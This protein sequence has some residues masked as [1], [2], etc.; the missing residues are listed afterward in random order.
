MIKFMIRSMSSIIS[1][2]IISSSLVIIIL[3]I[4]SRKSSTGRS[5]IRCCFGAPGTWG[6]STVNPYPYADH[7][8]DIFYTYYISGSTLAWPIAKPPASQATTSMI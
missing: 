8:G 7:I 5:C 4:P 2:A 6:D 1:S 3:S